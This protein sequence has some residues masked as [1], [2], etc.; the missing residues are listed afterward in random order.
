MRL[1]FRV[2]EEG[3]DFDDFG[4]L[5]GE[6]VHKSLELAIKQNLTDVEKIKTLVSQ[7]GTSVLPAGM[8]D[9][10]K[11]KVVSEAEKILEASKT[12]L[13]SVFSLFS[14]GKVF[15]EA[16]LW[17]GTRGVRPDVVCVGEDVLV[18]DFKTGEE[19]PSSYKDQI[20]AYR[21]VVGRMFPDRKVKCYL[22]FLNE[23]GGQ[24]CEL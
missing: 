13:E 20:E 6:V 19:D 11:Q 22:A 9:E 2:S 3:V 1:I 5:V 12:T 17:Q 18:I 4:V 15:S 24:L 14:R 8:D 7:A 23:R 10:L 16:E 21:A